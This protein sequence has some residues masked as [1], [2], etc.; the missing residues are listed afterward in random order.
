MKAHSASAVNAVILIVMSAWG[1]LSSATPSLTALIPAAF[2]VGL[3]ACLPGV[4]SENKVVAHIAV[5]LTLI[6]LIAL[7]MPLRGAINRGDSL[8]IV[9]VGLMLVST[10]IAFVFFINSFRDAR[11]ARQAQGN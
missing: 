6:V 2:A 10:V 5:L 1:Y 8:A 11:K 3:L 9:R 7:F 4:K